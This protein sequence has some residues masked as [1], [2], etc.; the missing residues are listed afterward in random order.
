MHN[1]LNEIFGIIGCGLLGICTAMF[2]KMQDITNAND[3]LNFKQVASLYLKKAWASYG[4]SF[5]VVVIYA[6]THES[7]IELFVGE[8]DSHSI[9]SK[10]I[11]MVMLMGVMVGFCMQYGYYRF[12]LKKADAFMKSWGGNTE[13][14]SKDTET[15]SEQ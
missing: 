4:A 7:W 10:I 1:E 13:D 3:N 14:R 9:V 12:A 8:K 11:G 5:T 6:I 15:K 2:L